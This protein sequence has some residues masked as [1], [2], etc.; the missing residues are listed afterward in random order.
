MLEITHR[1]CLSPLPRHPCCTRVVGVR[2]RRRLAGLRLLE[3]GIQS[4]L[5]AG[6]RSHPVVHD[7]LAL[8]CVPQIIPTES[9][10][11][12]DNL[13]VGFT[14]VDGAKNSLS[15][16]ASPD[17]T[18]IILSQRLA[19]YFCEPGVTHGRQHTRVPFPSRPRR[20][21]IWRDRSDAQ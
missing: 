16:I 2:L 20:S 21:P 18:H 10:F 9:R 15:L 11:Y 6:F 12:I 5:G 13:D 1:V 14:A 8:V 4:G 19:R 17:T 3:N 7:R